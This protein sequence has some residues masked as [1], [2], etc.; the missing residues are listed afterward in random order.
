MVGNMSDIKKDLIEEVKTYISKERIRQRVVALSLTIEQ[1]INNIQIL[2]IMYKENEDKNEFLTDIYL[3][4]GQLYSYKFKN[5][6]VDGISFLRNIVSQSFIEEVF[7]RNKKIKIPEKSNRKQL[8]DELSRISKNIESTPS[9]KGL[10]IHGERGSGKT[11]ILKYFTYV[12]ASKGKKVAFINMLKLA[13]FLS[14][15]KS[16]HIKQ[17]FYE[18]LLNVEIL[19]IDDIGGEYITYELRDDFLFRLLFDRSEKGKLTFFSSAYN[20]NSLIDIESKTLSRSWKNAP[21]KEEID[22][23]KNLVN[24]IRILAK[25]FELKSDLFI[26]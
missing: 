4:D 16:I 11:F 20:L 1:M 17:D 21:V 19:V 2:E 15:N 9:Q 23:A 6:K 3:K 10:Y 7:D 22:K 25:E 13:N 5:P 24:K 12:L 26:E 18:T 14:E 8:I